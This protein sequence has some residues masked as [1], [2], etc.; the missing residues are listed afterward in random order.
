MSGKVMRLQGITA[1]VSRNAFLVHVSAS[2]MRSFYL[3][4]LIHIRW[5]QRISVYKIWLAG[6]IDMLSTKEVNAEPL[7][8]WVPQERRCVFNFNPESGQTRCWQIKQLTIMYNS[9][10]KSLGGHKYLLLDQQ[11]SWNLH[12]MLY[13]KFNFNWCYMSSGAHQLTYPFS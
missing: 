6:R 9:E 2:W 10:V 12:L 7:K 4:V 11:K 13:H 3:T 8:F 1:S 5:V